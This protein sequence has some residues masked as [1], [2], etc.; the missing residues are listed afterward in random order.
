LPAEIQD[1]K[2]GDCSRDQ[3]LKSPTLAAAGDV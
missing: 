3:S 1:A 2:S